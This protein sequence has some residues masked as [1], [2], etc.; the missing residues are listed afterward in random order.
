MTIALFWD[1]TLCCLVNVPDVSAALSKE[2]SINTYNSIWCHIPEES[3]IS[4]H[5]CAKFGPHREKK[6]FLLALPDRAVPFPHGLI[7]RPGFGTTG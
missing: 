6:F 4:N 1:M 2:T 7:S 5:R 3:N